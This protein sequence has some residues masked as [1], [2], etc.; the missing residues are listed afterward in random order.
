MLENKPSILLSAFGIHTGGGLVLLKALA[1]ALRDDLKLATLDARLQ[2]DIFMANYKERITY[3]RK[4]FLARFISLFKLASSAQSS[5]ILF[6]FNSLPPFFRPTCRVIAY[7]QAP[8]FANM[9]RDSRYTLR[10]SLRIWVERRWFKFGVKNCSELWVQTLTMAEQLRFQYPRANVRVMPFV[11]DDLAEKLTLKDFEQ[12]VARCESSKFVFFYPADAVGHKNHVNLIKAW[13]ILN[14]Y[15]L[16]PV[17]LLTLSEDEIERVSAL[18]G[19]ELA[20][21]KNIENLG[22]ISRSEVLKYM[23][24]SSAMIFPSRA[25]TFGLP[26]LEARACG[27]PIIAS[28]RDFVRDVCIPTTTFDPDSPLSIARAAMRFMSMDQQPLPILNASQFVASVF[29]KDMQ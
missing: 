14:S 4:S 23:A 13:L 21:F 19:V 12:H 7:V 11:D 20:L 5:D 25:E 29:N 27:V 8:H 17:L 1:F 2:D 6:C 9:H 15:R 3:V 26:M 18:T 16:F 22:R 24:G 28:E 10:T